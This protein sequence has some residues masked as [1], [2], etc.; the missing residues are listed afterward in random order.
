MNVNKLGAIVLDFVFGLLLVFNASG[1]FR[2]FSADMG[3]PISIFTSFSFFVNLVYIAIYFKRTGFIYRKR[4]F[5]NWMILLL[6]WPLFT[7][8]YSRSI[9]ITNILLLFFFNSVFV[10]SIVFCLV[11]NLRTIK[12]VFGLSILISIIGG[13]LSIVSPEIFLPT[14]RA[15]NGNEYLSALGRA[16][17]FEIQ[18]NRLACNI[19]LMFIIWIGLQKWNANSIKFSLSAIVLFAFILITGSRTGIVISLVII[20]L[21]T[22][23]SLKYR[24]TFLLRLKNYMVLGTTS[25]IVTI[26]LASFIAIRNP[27]QAIAQ[28]MN[29]LIGMVPFDKKTRNI[30]T[31]SNSDNPKRS[32]LQLAYIKMIIKRPWG[33]GFKG[34]QHYLKSGKLIMTAHS[35]FLTTA[36]QYSIIYPFAFLL[37]MSNFLEKKRRKS[38]EKKLDTN[39]ILQFLTVFFLLYTYAQ[40]TL[41]SRAFL[42]SFA[43]IYSIFYYPE[44]LINDNK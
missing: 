32:E 7:L 24:S 6:I 23:Y 28:R 44:I 8:P 40:G 2:F 5:L 1:F 11:N 10:S 34:D 33:Y 42:I 13:I 41:T 35:E 31:K 9:E 29:W 39:F 22:L 25:F 38:V 19:C 3:I 43:F 30:T 20:F 12:I 15:V 36:F 27:D 14:I 18:A 37:V 4:H 17:G 26:S 21:G 16:F